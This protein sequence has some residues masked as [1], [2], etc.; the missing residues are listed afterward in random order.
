MGG[1]A[2]GVMSISGSNHDAVRDGRG[3]CAV[4]RCLLQKDYPQMTQ[5]AADA[6]LGGRRIV[7]FTINKSV[8]LSF[9][10]YDS[11]DRSADLTYLGG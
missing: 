9:E 11:K 6:G 1:L 10:S 5:M 4:T 3:R 7:C 8:T 2:G